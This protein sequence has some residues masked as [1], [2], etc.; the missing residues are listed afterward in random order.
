MSCEYETYFW[1][2]WSDQ[3]FLNIEA[4]FGSVSLVITVTLNYQ[5]LSKIKEIVIINFQVPLQNRLIGYIT[6][7]PVRFTAIAF[8]TES[9]VGHWF[10]GHHKGLLPLG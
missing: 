5:Y 10:L 8:A 7:E 4:G 2:S 6:P 9:E 1:V 3:V